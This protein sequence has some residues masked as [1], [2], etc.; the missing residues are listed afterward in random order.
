MA[1]F[2]N[3]SPT[4]LNISPKKRSLDAESNAPKKPR[5]AAPKLT[6]ARYNWR[7]NNPI[8]KAYEDKDGNHQV[9]FQNP[10][11]RSYKVMGPPGV[12]KF[13][14]LGE[15]G[16]I[17]RFNWCATEKTASM[18]F[19]YTNQPLPMREN[20]TA[21][22]HAKRI[23]PYSQNQQE[24]LKFLKDTARQGFVALY[25][26]V[27][28]IREQF[29]KK[30]K[31]VL[32]DDSGD[33]KLNEMALKLMIKAGMNKI[34]IK[35]NGEGGF[36]FNVKC[37]AFEGQGDK[38]TPKRVHVYSNSYDE[39]PTITRYDIKSG[40]VISPVFAIRLYTLPGYKTFG[41]TFQL[42]PNHIVVHKNGTDMGERT[43]G[44]LPESQLKQ[45]EYQM[46]GVTSKSGKY[47]VYVNDL[48]GSKYLHRAP[49]MTTKYCNLENGTLDKFPGQ[50]EDTA[51]L[52]ATF[53]E[54]DSNKEYFDHIEQ[55]VRD[56]GAYLLND[57]NVMKDSKDELRQTAQDI[58]EET[59]GDVDT[60][61]KNLFMGQIQSPLKE[62]GSERQLRISQ[63]MFKAARTGA[64]SDEPRE[65]NVF[66]YENKDGKVE[67]D[68][69]LEH[70]CTL[71]P[72]LEPRVYILPNGTA[73]VTLSADL[74][75]PI[76]IT[77][78][79]NFCVA[80]NDIPAYTDDDF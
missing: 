14:E 4:S 52:T 36:E 58:A 27:G 44:R 17:G 25:N 68:P 1:T 56:V 19:I 63:R 20:E 9:Q 59:S 41:V 21:D 29:M 26:S 39:H 67:E 74:A 57:N 6:T 78:A 70:G 10:S 76:I 35:E 15:G 16:N 53:V 34:P 28:A 5:V 18:G 45:R 54:D 49:P 24:F 40:A 48:S 8:I 22:E 3:T 73:G 38:Y 23:A 30:A 11:G 47:N 60:T 32:S 77:N 31:S 43:V 65:R 50:T 80:G 75:H 37:G 7:T 33:D 13:V 2:V 61:M 55:L 71:A 62:V 51:R 46:K 79:P 69:F 66:T 72:V 64:D 42:E 12:T